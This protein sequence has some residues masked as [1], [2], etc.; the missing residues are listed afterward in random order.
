MADNIENP[1]GELPEG[2]P[3]REPV[4]EPVHDYEAETVVYEPEPVEQ[5]YT[6]DDVEEEA[7]QRRNNLLLGGLLIL[8]ILVGALLL[9]IFLNRDGG[10]GGLIPI[11]PSPDTSD[12]SWNRVR[13]AGRMV[14]GTSLDNPPFSYRDAQFQP[15][16][17]DI[18]LIQEIANRLGV[19]TE[20]RDMAFDSLGNALNQGQVDVAI[21]A[22][23]ITP[24]REQQLDFSNVYYVGEEGILARADS[25]IT[26]VASLSDMAGRRI[27]VQRGSVYEAWLQRDLVDSGITAAGN[28]LVYETADAVVRDLRE[29]RLD[30]AILDRRPAEAAVG[31]GGVKL[32]GSGL[33]PQ[34]YAIAVRPG[35]EALR[36]QLNAALLQLQNESRLN[37][38]IQQYLNVNPGDII[39]PAPTTPVQ[40]TT[41]PVI[42]PTAAP[43]SNGM[44]FIA[45]LNLDDNNMQSPPPVSPGQAFSKG[46]RIQNSGTCAWTTSFR[47]VF[48]S[49]NVPGASMGGQPTPVQAFVQPGQQYD[50]FVN[51]VAP[52][53]PGVYQGVWQMVDEQNRPFGDRIWVGITVP[54]PA[55]ATPQPTQTPSP[56]IQFTV[57]STDIV[58]GQCVTFT[59]NVQNAS[60]VFFFAQGEAWQNNQVTPQN[61]RVVCPANTTTYFLRVTKPGGGVEERQIA[62]NV[63]PSVGAPVIALFNASPAQVT[64]GQCVQLQWDVQ[65]SVTRVTVSNQFRVIWDNAPVRGNTQD[66]TGAPATVEY[67]LQATGPGGAS[68]ALGYVNVV[69]PATA[70]PVPT[71]VPSE[72][73]IDAFEITPTQIQTGQCVQISWRA[74]GATWLV[75]LLRNNVLVLDNAGLTGSAQDC[76]QT[77]GT[78]VYQLVASTA[79]GQST[80]RDQ[81]VLVTEAPPVNPLAGKSFDLAALN[82]NPLI[83]DT[84]IS[85]TFDADGRMNGNG[86]CN[87]FSGRYTAE[88]G[89]ITVTDISIGR[90]M[91]VIPEGVME[92]EQAF[93]DALRAAVVFELSPDNGLLIM[94]NIVRDEVL[95]FTGRA[96]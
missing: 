2:Q 93:I 27:G 49:G 62:I 59:W 42:D 61:T 57:N 33:N 90:V 30:L 13:T 66:C 72:P 38:L 3:L 41:P 10:S 81:S 17:F 36:G 68:Q 89:T 80:S 21:A 48:V 73:I 54:S 82:N 52:L 75:R 69:S 16:G 20:I 31:Q 43:C 92:Q 78:I 76:L 37:Q 14:V 63:R 35:A 9:Y 55:T 56:S 85:V 34:R 29:Q 77:A 15:T 24:E 74:S 6:L 50:M 4:H 67:R 94:R 83:T 32:V 58:Q 91:C 23:S 22:I 44:R 84:L 79:G 46:W 28:L 5:N 86:G 1:E 88:N 47:L 95:R 64:A 60:A 39:T 40:P 8:A 87:N 65:G 25:P 45:D 96:R 51:L 18:A 11:T 12:Q 71:A 19:G 7:N 26:A 70:T 53:A